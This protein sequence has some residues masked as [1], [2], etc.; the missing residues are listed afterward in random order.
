VTA[1]ELLDRFRLRAKDTARPYFWSDE[2][3]FDYIDA[4]YREFI[5][6]L[7]GIPDALSPATRA[8]IIAGEAFAPLHASILRTLFARR[9]SDGREIRLINF[10]DLS[11]PLADDRVGTVRAG[12]L[13]LQ[14]GW[15]RWVDVPAEDDVARLLIR[16]LPLDRLWMPEQ[17]LVDI[18]EEQH[19]PLLDGV[20]ALALAKRDAETFDLGRAEEYQARFL[21]AA[22]R[23]RQALERY[24]SKPRAVAYGGI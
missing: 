19:L 5:R 1:G 24:E 18:A 2:E 12:V 21:A 6:L 14:R 7:G 16:R 22:D 4:A 20:L 13:G 15:I 23:E 11:A 8:P 17:Q 9:A 10:T 3:V